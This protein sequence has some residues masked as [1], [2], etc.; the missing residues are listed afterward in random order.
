MGTKTTREGASHE[1]TYDRL[2]RRD[3]IRDG[4]RAAREAKASRS[5][6]IAQAHCEACGS[7]LNEDLDSDDG[8]TLCCNELTSSGR[9]DCRNHHGDSR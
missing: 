3:D 9:N 5:C 1:T 2:T 4:L 7:T 8:Y 6:T